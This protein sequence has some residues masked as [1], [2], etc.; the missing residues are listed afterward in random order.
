MVSIATWR[1]HTLRQGTGSNLYVL[2]KICMKFSNLG[3]NYGPA[4]IQC[5]YNDQ[6]MG[7][8]QKEL[9]DTKFIVFELVSAAATEKLFNI[10]ILSEK[11][12]GLG[13]ALKGRYHQN[14]IHTQNEQSWL[15][16][17]SVYV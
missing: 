15:K 4:D 12:S 2:F 1:K 3:L 14:G 5:L 10:H 9:Q 11:G 13:A 6:E 7:I 8:Y 17:L 16:F